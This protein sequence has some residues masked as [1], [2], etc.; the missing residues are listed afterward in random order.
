MDIHYDAKKNV[1]EAFKIMAD[2]EKRY[3]ENKYGFTDKK[4]ET[5]RKQVQVQKNYLK[6]K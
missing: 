1:P 5:C 3:S 4:M 2:L 6:I